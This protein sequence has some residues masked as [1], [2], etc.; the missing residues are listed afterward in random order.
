MATRTYDL[1]ILPLRHQVTQ[2]L[3]GV[4]NVHIALSPRRPARGRKSDRLIIFLLFEGEH[5]FS[6]ARVQQLLETM[7]KVYFSTSGSV[8]SA[9]RVLIEDL[10]DLYKVNIAFEK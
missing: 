9:I 5:S 8:T 2:E 4:P 1:N 3:G 10:N 6:R 7:E